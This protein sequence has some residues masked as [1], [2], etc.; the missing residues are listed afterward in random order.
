VTLGRHHNFFYSLSLLSFFATPGLAAES[1]TSSYNLFNPVPEN[2]MKEMISDRADKT[3]GPYIVEP[4]HYHLEFDLFSYTRDRRGADTKTTS[5]TIFGPTIR[6]GLLPCLEFNVILETYN[7]ERTKQETK[8]GFGDTVLRLKYNFWGNDGKGKTALGVIPFVK[9]PTNQDDLGNN[10]VEGGI[11]LPLDIKITDNVSLGLMTQVNM[12]KSH[13]NHSRVAEF[14]NSGS[15]SYSFT[16]KLSGF[17]ELYTS[18]STDGGS[19]WE[20]TVDF[21]LVYNVTKNFQVDAGINIGVSKAADDF[22][23]FI[24]ASIRF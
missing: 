10:S 18:K 20:N 12:N 16:E 13:N 3:E 15:L 7:K 17:G 24:G 9:L 6:V 8:S 11:M 1:M 4:G 19:D 23:P 21:G 14:V 2:L 5:Y 22:N